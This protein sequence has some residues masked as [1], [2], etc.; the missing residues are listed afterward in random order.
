MAS[1]AGCVDHIALFGNPLPTVGPQ[2][3]RSWFGDIA[4][5]AFLVAQ[6]LDGVFTY[7]GV[8]TYGLGIEAN[9]LVAGLMT[10]LGYEAG[11]LGAKLMASVLGVCLHLRSVHRAVAILAAFYFAVAIGPWSVILFM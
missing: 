10:Y 1:T 11:L 4:L 2:L 6:C 7:V 5:I 9:P 3:S 8:T